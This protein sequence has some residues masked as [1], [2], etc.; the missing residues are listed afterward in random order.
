MIRRFLGKQKF[1]LSAKG[2]TNT[3]LHSCTIGER[4]PWENLAVVRLPAS[5]DFEVGRAKLALQSG[6]LDAERNF[7]YRAILDGTS[8]DLGLCDMSGAVWV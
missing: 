1:S 2:M 7:S 4:I 6:G 5:M 8:A 3:F